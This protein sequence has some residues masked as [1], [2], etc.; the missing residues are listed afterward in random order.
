MIKKF[1]LETFR[2]IFQRNNCIFFF[3]YIRK[4]TGHPFRLMLCWYPKKTK[5]RFDYIYKKLF[6][7]IQYFD[8]KILKKFFFWYK[9]KK[10]VILKILKMLTTFS[11]ENLK[12]LSYFLIKSD[13]YLK[14]VDFKRKIFC[15][16]ICTPMQLLFN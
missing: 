13:S 4:K 3:Q 5:Y 15:S 8:G 6:L 12:S 7:K 9:Y 1:C 10:R 16:N 11:F 14:K 2:K